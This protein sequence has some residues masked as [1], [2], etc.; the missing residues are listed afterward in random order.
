MEEYRLIEVKDKK[1]IPVYTKVSLHRFDELNKYNWQFMGFGHRKR[2]Y[3]NA[4]QEEIRCGSK[5]NIAMHRQIMNFPEYEV[6]HIDRDPL[7]NTDT[8]LRVAST[9]Q[10]SYNRGKRKN[11]SS[12][13]KGV[14]FDQGTKKWQSNVTVAKKR[15]Y[16]GLYESEEYAAKV[17]DG[18]AIA[19]HK[20][21]AVLNFPAS[22]AIP[23]SSKTNTR[24]KL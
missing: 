3:R 15:V 4:S 11:T 1:D 14:S 20:E 24:K 7:N 5:K 10:N 12:K 21:F 8:N 9:L 16:L 19:L 13:Y 17:R 6:D 23:Y 18:A 22:E 2:V